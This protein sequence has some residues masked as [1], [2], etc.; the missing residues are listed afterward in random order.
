MLDRLK[1]DDLFLKLFPLPGITH[2]LIEGSLSQ[3]HT[4][5]PHSRSGAI[6]GSH[7][8][9]ETQPLF[10]NQILLGNK[11]ILEYQLPCGRCP[12]AHL[13]FFLPKSKTRGSLL[14][15]KGTCPPGSFC[16]IG[17]CNDR[18][19]L[20][21]PSIGDPLLCSIQHIDISSPGSRR[22]DGT[23]ITP[24]ISLCQ[25]KSGQLFPPCNIREIFFLLFG[26]SK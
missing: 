1:R 11:T 17:H 8:N 14:N 15:N 4:L 16:S 24:S 9:D 23:G 22:S 20:R 13:L 18:I 26:V 3:S 6:K 21:L 2:C 12:D 19:N 7:G 10:P 5:S 25:P